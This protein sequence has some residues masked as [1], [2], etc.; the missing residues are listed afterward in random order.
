MSNTGGV[1]P[2][3]VEMPSPFRQPRAVWAVAFACVICFM[4]IGLVDPILPSM[5]SRLK[6]S[7]S[8]VEGHTI[9]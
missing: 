6:A 1:L 7:P 2:P 8:Q 3:A 4:G 9:V 5:V